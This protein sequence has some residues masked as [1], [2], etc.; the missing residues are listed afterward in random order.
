LDFDLKQLT[1]WARRAFGDRARRV[2][3]TQVGTGSADIVLGNDG[4]AYINDGTVTGVLKDINDNVVL[5]GAAIAF[6]YI[7]ASNGNYS[8]IV[9]HDVDFLEDRDYTLELTIVKGDVQALIKITR[10]ARYNAL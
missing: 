5:N 8:G 6:T 1:D 10:T 9:A 2:R 4:G 3:E 7:V